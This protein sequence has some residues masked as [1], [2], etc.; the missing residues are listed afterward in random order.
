VFA[1]GKIVVAG[2]RSVAD[3]R[4][5]AM[6]YARLLQKLGFPARFVGFRVRNLVARCAVAFKIRLE[7]F[8][9]EQRPLSHYEPELFPA[10]FLDL[11]K[12]KTMVLVFG[13]GR[14][15]ITGARSDEDAKSAWRQVQ[16][17]LEEFRRDESSDE[18]KK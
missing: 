11:R 8:A 7:E 9:E 1:T 3:A 6:K 2:A 14:V 18:K 12:P 4:L 16:P 13:S 17:V 15:V 10:V 5:A